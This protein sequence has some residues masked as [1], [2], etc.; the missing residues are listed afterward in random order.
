MSRNKNHEKHPQLSRLESTIHYARA[1]RL[2]SAQNEKV[3]IEEPSGQTR[4]LIDLMS[5]YAS[6][7]F[8]HCNPDIRP[9]DNY[10]GDLVSF[11]TPIEAENFAMWLCGRLHKKTSRVLF[12]VGGT[13]AVS[14]A[15]GMAQRNRPG[16]VVAIE[17]GFHGLAVDALSASDIGKGTIM[18]YTNIGSET[19][20]HFQIIAKGERAVDWSQVSCLIFEPVQGASGMLP[21]EQEWIASLCQD[22]RTNGVIVIADEIQCGYYRCGH[23]SYSIAQGV[24]ADILLFGKSMTNGLFPFAALVYERTLEAPFDRERG[25]FAHTYQP[26]ALGCYAAYSVAMYLDLHEVD[27]RVRMLNEILGT[28]VDDLVAHGYVDQAYILGPSASMRYMKGDAAVIADT[29]FER[30]VLMCLGGPAN[31]RFRLMP[32]LTISPQVLEQ[33]L[34]VLKRAIEEDYKDS[35]QVC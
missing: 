6:V 1:A 27:S 18:Q 21:L 35:R 24:E 33:G 3:V 31:D 14:A 30:G 11:F 22:A 28:F 2:I 17:G 15:I 4:A 16:K 26:S 19:A 34:S 29:C 5:S 20:T 12:Q 8:G 25:C 10:K 13:S 9:Y 23:M 32:P 7:N